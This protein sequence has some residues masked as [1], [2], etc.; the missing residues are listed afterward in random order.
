MSPEERARRSRQVTG[1]PGVFMRTKGM[2]HGN[3]EL[4]RQIL[5]GMPGVIDQL[6]PGRLLKLGRQTRVT[7]NAQKALLVEKF[8][9]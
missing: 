4:T 1:N 3:P 8:F 2:Q 9:S 7:E 5:E 6:N